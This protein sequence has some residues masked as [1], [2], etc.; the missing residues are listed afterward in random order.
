MGSYISSI[1]NNMSWGFVFSKSG[2]YYVGIILLMLYLLWAFFGSKVK[3]T[4]VEYTTALEDSLQKFK[5]EGLIDIPQKIE[6]PGSKIINVNNNPK[7]I[8]SQSTKVIISDEEIVNRQP[9]SKK[10][11]K[12]ED[13]CHRILEELTGKK[14]EKNARPDFLR[15]PQ[16][17][18][19]L[20]L[21][22][23]DGVGIALEYQGIQHYKYPNP[24][25]KSEKEFEYQI[26]KDKW[27]FDK[28]EEN[29]VFLIRVPY[30]IPF[31]KLKSYIKSRLDLYYEG[32]S[33]DATSCYL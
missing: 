3:S 2:L 11:L 16:T 26:Q 24:F 19:N 14:F 15:N 30:N 10:K 32:K 22:C 17:S 18:R 5:E 25:H 13:E 12:F 7:N 6:A 8:N 27:K 20:E 21:D 28:C 9:F 23:F 1:K 29:N 4:L 31:K 33:V